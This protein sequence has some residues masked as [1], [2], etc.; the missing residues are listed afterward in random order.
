MALTSLMCYYNLILIHGFH[1]KSIMFSSLSLICASLRRLDPKDLTMLGFL[2]Q[3]VG[4]GARADPSFSTALSLALPSPRNL[5]LFV[6]RMHE[7]KSRFIHLSQPD[8]LDFSECFLQSLWRPGRATYAQ[9]LLIIV[10]M[11]L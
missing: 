8:L 3:P 2:G 6:V 5:Y 4:H 7:L 11:Y 9:I 10:F 1:Y